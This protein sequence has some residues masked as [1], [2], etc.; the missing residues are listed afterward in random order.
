MVTI[1]SLIDVSLH[2]FFIPRFNESRRGHC[3]QLYL[4]TCKSNIRS[5][6]FNY[7]VI[8]N[9]THSQVALISHHLKDFINPWPLNYCSHIVRYFYLVVRVAYRKFYVFSILYSCAC[10]LNDFYIYFMHINVSGRSV[11]LFN[12]LIKSKQET[13]CLSFAVAIGRIAV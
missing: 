8:Q 1:N 13:C 4:P 9:G 2:D 7:R 6:S 10:S 11:L 12:K 5:N 3:Y